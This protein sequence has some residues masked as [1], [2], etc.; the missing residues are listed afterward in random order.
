MRYD[1]EVP[2]SIDRFPWEVILKVNSTSWIEKPGGGRPN[3]PVA[4]VEDAEFAYPE[5]VPQDI[6]D[7]GVEAFVEDHEEFLNDWA[8]DNEIDRHINPY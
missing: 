3:Y 2:V 7:E 4:R 1:A 5:D 6:L 8:L